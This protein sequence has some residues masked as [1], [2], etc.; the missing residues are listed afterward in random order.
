MSFISSNKPTHQTLLSE[1][2]ARTN[3]ELYVQELRLDVSAYVHN[4]VVHLTYVACGRRSTL[5]RTWIHMV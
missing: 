4:Y 1:Y 5:L 3:E 2:S